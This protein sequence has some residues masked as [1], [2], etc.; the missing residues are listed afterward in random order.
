MKQILLPITLLLILSAC[1]TKPKTELQA[2]SNIKGTAVYGDSVK[3]DNVIDLSAMLT[4]MKDESQKDF[5]IKGVVNE[6]CEKKGC[7]MTMKLANGEN[8]RVTFKDYKIF[9]P[10][11]LEGKEVILDGFAYTDTVS[12]DD[13][14]HFAL[15]AG[16]NPVEIASI[17][18][19]KT[20]L[21]YEA[22]GVVVLN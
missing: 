12:V 4:A 13:Q 5:K 15:D 19:P 17:K 16:K 3:N 8:L 20:E 7:W 14:K 1:N 22:R 11:T 18:D 10:K 21:A 6:V 9:V 2:I